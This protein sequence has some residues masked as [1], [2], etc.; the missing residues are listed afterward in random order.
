MSLIVIFFQLPYRFFNFQNKNLGNHTVLK[1]TWSQ[2]SGWKMTEITGEV[3]VW[4]SN[5]LA[6]SCEELTHWKRPW[7]WEG[8]GAG[9]EGDDR[10]SDGWMATLTWWA[11][12]WVNS[13]SLWWTGRPGGCDSWGHKESDTTEQLNGTELNSV[14]N[15][16]FKHS[17]L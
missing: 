13:G 9:G 10:G 1:F 2:K 4:N 12:V 8:L 17:I 7:C 16:G 3:I 11:L 5:T 6:T 15:L 14:S